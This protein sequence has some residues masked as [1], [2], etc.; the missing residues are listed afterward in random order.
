MLPWIAKLVKKPDEKPPEPVEVKR[1]QPSV[2]A[3]LAQRAMKR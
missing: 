2:A 1:P 3:I